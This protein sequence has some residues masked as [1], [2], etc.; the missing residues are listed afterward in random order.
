MATV[1]TS[2]DDDGESV[3]LSFG[4]PLPTGV[5]AAVNDEAIVSI[6]NVSAQ[7]L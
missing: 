7:T 2:V 6:T 3:K 4:S 1:R 5:S